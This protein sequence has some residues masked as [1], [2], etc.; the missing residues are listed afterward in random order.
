MHFGCMVV[1]RIRDALWVRMHFGCFM[2][3]HSRWWVKTCSTYTAPYPKE[4]GTVSSQDVGKCAHNVTVRV[5]SVNLV[6]SLIYGCALGLKC[7]LY[8]SKSSKCFLFHPAFSNWC[9]VST[10]CSTDGVLQWRQTWTE[11]GMSTRNVGNTKLIKFC[12]VVAFV[13]WRFGGT[14]IHIYVAFFLELTQTVTQSM[15]IAAYR[16]IELLS[17]WVSYCTAYWVYR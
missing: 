13:T 14:K 6:D 4:D 15:Y 17:C 16:E 12:S 1:Y 7:A 3:R 11:I 5:G 8:T 10:T 9:S 2:Q